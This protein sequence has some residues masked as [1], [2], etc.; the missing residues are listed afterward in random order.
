MRIPNQSQSVERKTVTKALHRGVGPQT[1]HSCILPIFRPPTHGRTAPALP[2]ASGFRIVYSGPG[3]IRAQCHGYDECNQE[4]A[5][6][7][8]GGG[9]FNPQA[10]NEWGGV[11][12]GMCLTAPGHG[13]PPVS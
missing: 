10:Y 12:Q 5:D 11:I 2:A 8:G 13:K 1:H 3:P 6:C 7:I 4:I 9:E